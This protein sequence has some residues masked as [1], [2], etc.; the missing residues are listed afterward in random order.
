MALFHRVLFVRQ[1]VVFTLNAIVTERTEETGTDGSGRL[2]LV[3]FEY[4]LG[5]HQ[6]LH[7]RVLSTSFSLRDGRQALEFP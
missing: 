7:A 3:L 6:K 2:V 5:L 1:R 4:A